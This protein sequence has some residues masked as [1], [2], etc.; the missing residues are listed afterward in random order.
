MKYRDRRMDRV[1]T[2]IKVNPRR[3]FVAIIELIPRSKTEAAPDDP[4]DLRQPIREYQSGLSP[5]KLFLSLFFFPGK[6]ERF[7]RKEK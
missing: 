6:K 3:S 2:V 7:Y 4:I 1:T 5:H